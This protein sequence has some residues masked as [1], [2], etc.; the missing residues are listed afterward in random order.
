MS[1]EPARPSWYE[2]LLTPWRVSLHPNES[3]R[4]LSFPEA[5]AMLIEARLVDYIRLREE[6]PALPSLDESTPLSDHSVDFRLL[7]ALL[8]YLTGRGDAT[9]MFL[10]ASR[11][12]GINS[13]QEVAATLLAS[14]ALSEGGNLPAAITALQHSLVRVQSDRLGTALLELNLG[15]RHAER[16]AWTDAISATV[17]ATNVLAEDSRSTDPL[18]SGL[19][20]VAASNLWTYRMRIGEDAGNLPIFKQEELPHVLSRSSQLEAGA[21]RT[22]LRREFETEFADPYSRGFRWSSTDET[23]QGLLAALL[24]KEITA[25]FGG[26]RRARGLI[27]QYRLIESLRGGSHGSAEAFWLLIRSDASKLVG[28]AASMIMRTGPLDELRDV[29]NEAAAAPWT[30]IVM[31]GVL[32]LTKAA[33][34]LVDGTARTELVDRLLDLSRRSLALGREERLYRLFGHEPIEALS[35]VVR[36]TSPETQDRAARELLVLVQDTSDSV[37][38]NAIA[39]ALTALDWGLLPA[40]SRLAW[41]ELG[42]S[43]LEDHHRSELAFTVLLMLAPSDSEVFDILRDHFVRE[44]SVRTAAAVLDSGFDLNESLVT[45]IGEVA[46]T[47]VKEIQEEARKGKYSIGRIDAVLLLTVLQ[48]RY[49]GLD[50]WSQIAAVLT[51]PRV[52]RDDKQRTCDFLAKRVDEIPTQIRAQLCSQPDGVLADEAPGFFGPSV[53]AAPA[54][55]LLMALGCLEGADVL[56][57]LLELAGADDTGSRIE[58]ARSLKIAESIAGRDALVSIAL[59]LSHDRHAEVRAQAGHALTFLVDAVAAEPVGRTVVNRIRELLA[60]PGTACPRLVL[61]GL[62]GRENLLEHDE[63]RDLVARLSEKHPSTSIRRLA[64]EVLD[65]STPVQ[66]RDP[67]GT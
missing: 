1:P 25:D 4:Q 52:A 8:R 10:A 65:G 9:E 31:E 56:K 2:V 64:E 28:G 23:D 19:S 53:P 16:G 49:P 50:Y 38:A 45:E 18:L 35:R 32:S 5:A 42:G 12:P 58:A 15:F 21:L 6:Q 46:G 36:F 59:S 54:L 43:L 40:E 55:R 67:S 26:V 17:E 41:R 48:L 30:S 20:R 66:P 7:V 29:V 34:D 27:G 3:H 13:D 22:F 47:G 62:L 14:I 51:D 24:H 39:Q 37:V 61:S 60:E 33:A 57:R 44:R 11:E 63:V